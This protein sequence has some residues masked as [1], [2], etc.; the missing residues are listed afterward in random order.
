MNQDLKRYLKSSA[1]TFIA[2]F[3]FFAVPTLVD[4][5]FTWTAPTVVSVLLSAIRV[6]VK[7][8]WE[9]WIPFLNDLLKKK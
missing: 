6:G 4:G 1:I 3:A 8:A 9:I 5:N 7:A 2:T